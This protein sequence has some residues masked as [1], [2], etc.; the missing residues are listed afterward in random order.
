MC[1]EY[2]LQ[3]SPLVQR[4]ARE[5]LLVLTPV[6]W[7]L[8]EMSNISSSEQNHKTPAQVDFHLFLVKQKRD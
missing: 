5:Q 8:T 7:F 3:F 4:L 1:A 6:N 2:W